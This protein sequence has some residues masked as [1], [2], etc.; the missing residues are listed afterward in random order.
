MSLKF[1]YLAYFGELN[2][3]LSGP[4]YRNLNTKKMEQNGNAK[5]TKT[6]YGGSIHSTIF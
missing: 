2:P 3:E 6:I 1:K 4:V 5:R